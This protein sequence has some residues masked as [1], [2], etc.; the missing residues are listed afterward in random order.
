MKAEKKRTG[1]W[2]KIDKEGLC[3]Q[4]DVSDTEQSKIQQLCLCRCKRNVMVKEIRVEVAI[5]KGHISRICPKRVALEKT[6]DER[7]PF[8]K[9]AW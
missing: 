6:N 4:D 7:K 1:K 3:K 5:K 8:M 2:S 9:S